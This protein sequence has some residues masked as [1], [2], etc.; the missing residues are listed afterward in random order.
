[1]SES[2]NSRIPYRKPW[3]SVSDQVQR[4]IDR[5]V[6][7]SD[8]CEAER[9]IRHSNYYRFTGYCL[10]FEESS[11]SSSVIRF[12]HVRQAYQFDASLRDLFTE[13]LELVE[14]DLRTSFAYKFGE[15]YG[16]F[17]Y[18][19]A[20]NFSPSFGHNDWLRRMREET[21]R[22]SERFKGHF[23]AK[24]VE[25]PDIPIWVATEVM[26]FGCLSR[27]IS[28]MKRADRTRVSAEY[29]IKQRVLSS[30]AHHLS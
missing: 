28:G 9:F 11:S 12:E 7:V 13:A 20:Q 21:T 14:I 6:E 3:L 26:S 24:Y 8:K 1:M 10:A 22:S 4:L 18:R 15:I 16:S 23:E 5:G 30:F 17:G 27:M 25:F 2:S 29:G 19:E